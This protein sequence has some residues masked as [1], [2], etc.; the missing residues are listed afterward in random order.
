[1][2]YDSDRIYNNC[3]H[4]GSHLNEFTIVCW[5][6]FTL[7]RECR[8]DHLNVSHKNVFEEMGLFVSISIHTYTKI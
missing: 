7:T 5:N 2:Q 8:Q 6:F 4:L 3:I 1:M